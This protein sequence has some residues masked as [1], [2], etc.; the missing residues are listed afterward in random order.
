MEAK[1]PLNDS[2]FKIKTARVN[3]YDEV[4]HIGIINDQNLEYYEMISETSKV[5]HLEAQT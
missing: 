1:F 4:V 3:I 2:N 5:F